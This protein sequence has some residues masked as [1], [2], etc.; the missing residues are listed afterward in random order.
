[1]NS[2]LSIEGVNRKRKQRSS[3]NR[4]TDYTQGLMMLESLRK[5]DFTTLGHTSEALSR[6]EYAF[7]LP[8]TS[9]ARTPLAII[10]EKPTREKLNN[11]NGKSHIS[12]Q[13]SPSTPPV[14]YRVMS[15]RRPKFRDPY[16]INQALSIRKPRF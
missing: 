12:G 13:Y 3:F 6:E 9:R 10:K 16:G 2:Q 11:P 1:M 15:K 5:G 14:L 8:R 4:K 7:R